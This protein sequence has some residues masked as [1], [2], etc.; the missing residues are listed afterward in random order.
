MTTYDS[1]GAGKDAQLWNSSSHTP[2]ADTQTSC[3]APSCFSVSFSRSRSRRRRL[4]RRHRGRRRAR[5]SLFGGH[6]GRRR[7][8][9]W[10][11]AALRRW[12]CPSSVGMPSGSCQSRTRALWTGFPSSLGG[13]AHGGEGRD[14]GASLVSL[15]L[16]GTRLACAVSATTKECWAQ[17]S[18]MAASEGGGHLG[19][20]APAQK[21]PLM[22]TRRSDGR[23][24]RAQ[25][26]VTGSAWRGA[27]VELLS[28]ARGC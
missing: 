6:A 8:A 19:N 27:L 25:R 26:R 12:W 11:C 20:T 13:R 17:S 3:R 23:Q 15:A 9:I 24:A 22:R 21:A 16:V 5:P 4:H 14:T 2:R 10:G 1:T 18:K 7:R 28:R